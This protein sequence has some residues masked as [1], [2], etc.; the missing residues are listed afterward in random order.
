M[1]DHFGLMKSF[2]IM[3]DYLSSDS[4]AAGCTTIILEK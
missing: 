1:A 4:I 3:E 2:S